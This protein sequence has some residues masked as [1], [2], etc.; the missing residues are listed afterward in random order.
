MDEVASETDDLRDEPLEVLV[1]EDNDDHAELAERALT[2]DTAWT[3]RRVGTVHHARQTLEEQAFDLIVLDYRL[4][5][6]DG[7]DLLEHLREQRRSDPVIFLTGQGSEPVAMEA[8]EQGAL[9]YLVKGSDLLD[10]LERRALEAL[11]Q[12][13]AI[14]PLIEDELGLDRDEAAHVEVP[15]LVDELE[16]LVEGPVTGGLVRTPEGEIASKGLP[17]DVVGEDVGEVIAALHQN[18]GQLRRFDGLVPRRWSTVVQT[19]DHVLAISV[20]PGPLLIALFLRPSTGSMIALRRAQEA[21]RRLWETGS[22]GPDP[23]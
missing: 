2:A 23:N 7:L 3:V 19:P 16:G 4:P 20:A 15:G 18:L 21:S 11:Q 8:M 9:D 12:W 22:S 17:E 6:G 13:R 10:R 5:D 1:V 14:G